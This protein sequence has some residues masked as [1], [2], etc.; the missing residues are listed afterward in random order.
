MPFHATVSK[1]RA[2]STRLS[3][4]VTLPS[5]DRAQ[6]CLTSGIEREPVR[7]RGGIVCGAIGWLT[8]ELEKIGILIDFSRPEN[9]EHEQLIPESITLCTV[10]ITS[11]PQQ[12]ILLFYLSNVFYRNTLLPLG[13]EF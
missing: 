2:N 13:M 4:V 5:T 7:C 6:C 12:C 11:K 1:N 10:V 3:Q 8:A 9:S